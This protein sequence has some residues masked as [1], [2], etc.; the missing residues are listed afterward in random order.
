MNEQLQTLWTKWATESLI[1]A[2]FLAM[3]GTTCL[4]TGCSQMTLDDADKMLAIVEK[5]EAVASDTGMA[6]QASLTYNGRTGFVETA[7]FGIDT[8]LTLQATFQAN[9]ACARLPEG[10]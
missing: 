2:L 6:F 9:A 8:G 10:P 4:S 1:P 5:A 3:S 7:H